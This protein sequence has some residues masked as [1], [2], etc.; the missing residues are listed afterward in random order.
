MFKSSIYYNPIYIKLVSSILF[1]FVVDICWRDSFLLFFNKIVL[2]VILY[3]LLKCTHYI[4]FL[5]SFKFPPS[6]FREYTFI[7]TFVIRISSFFHAALIEHF[8]YTLH[9]L[10]P[11]NCSCYCFCNQ[12]KHRFAHPQASFGHCPSGCLTPPPW[13][14][15]SSLSVFLQRSFSMGFLVTRLR[16]FIASTCTSTLLWGHHIPG[17]ETLQTCYFLFTRK[18]FALLPTQTE[19]GAEPPSCFSNLTFLLGCPSGF[20]LCL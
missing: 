15:Y 16:S 18:G 1:G 12:C 6:Q 13:A 11:V 20:Y 10:V 14:Q 17:K 9:V 2:L 4:F 19:Q 8:N 5:P 7:H 3:P